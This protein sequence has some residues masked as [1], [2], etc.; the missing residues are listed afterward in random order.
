MDVDEKSGELKIKGQAAAEKRKTREE[1]EDQ[2]CL[3]VSPPATLAHRSVQDMPDQAE[4][5]RRESELKEKALRNKV[6]RTRKGS[7]NI[8]GS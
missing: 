6:V 1:E 8:G 3:M 4:L 7:A 2:V 5:E